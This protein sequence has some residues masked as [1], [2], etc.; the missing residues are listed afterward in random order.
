MLKV[1]FSQGINQLERGAGI[2]HP[3]QLHESIQ[4]ENNILIVNIL[5]ERKLEFY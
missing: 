1:Y 4:S 3:L 2:E 5:T